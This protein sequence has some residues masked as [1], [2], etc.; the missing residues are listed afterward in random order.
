MRPRPR[1]R[2]VLG[3]QADQGR[4]HHAQRRLVV[5]ADDQQ[6]AAALRRKTAAVGSLMAIASPSQARCRPRRLGPGRRAASSSASRR[7]LPTVG[8]R[9]CPRRRSAAGRRRLP[10][11]GQLLDPLQVLLAALVGEPDDLEGVVAFDQAVGVV[12]D[13]LAGPA[14]QPGGR[15]VLAEDQVGV[16]L[17]ALQGD[18]HRHLAD[19]CCGPASRPRRASASRAG[20]GCRTPGPAAPGGRAAAPPPARSCRPRR[21]T[22][23][24][25]RRSAGCAAAARWPWPVAVAGQVLHAARRGTDRR[26][27]RSSA[28]SRCSTLRPNSR[29]LSMAMTRACGSSM[30]GVGLELDAF[31]EVDQVELDLVGA[32]HAAPGW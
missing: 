20:R 19:A 32:V 17:A 26:A 29:S 9:H 1:R 7:F 25:R 28:S 2:D 13:R 21:R 11:R 3:G 15:V 6:V 22:P 27:A 10:L 18:A 16:G 4:G 23:G 24:T 8:R 30:R 14:E 5:L 31:L 12:V